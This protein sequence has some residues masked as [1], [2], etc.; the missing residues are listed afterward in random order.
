MS[1]QRGQQVIDEV[2]YTYILFFYNN[3]DHILQTKKWTLN[4]YIYIYLYILYIYI[5]I[6]LQVG[7]Q[8]CL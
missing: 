4:I 8:P 6:H 2:I 5:Y 7:H 1:S 3:D